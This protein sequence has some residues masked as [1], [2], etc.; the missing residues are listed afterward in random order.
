MKLSRCN[1]CEKLKPLDCF[2]P[3]KRSA[4]GVSYACKVCARIIF[5]DWKAKNPERFH[6][7]YLRARERMKFRYNTDK[8]YRDAVKA[9]CKKFRD[10]LS[11]EV[12][13]ERSR[14]HALKFNFG[15]TPKEYNAR[16]AKQNGGC[17]ICGI[18]TRRFHVDHDHATDKIRGILCD[19]CN[20]A[21]GVFGDNRRGVMR[22]IKYLEKN[23]DR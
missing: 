10:S 9:R 15:I 16:L 1:K 11:P 7:R 14:R 6:A 5:H 12:R 13:R 8:K 22:V 21:L 18:K 19:A 4:N 23:G 3:N 2:S 17:G 20:K